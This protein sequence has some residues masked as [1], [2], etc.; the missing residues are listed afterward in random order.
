MSKKFDFKFM[1]KG[2][3]CTDYILIKILW[4]K[5]NWF[6]DCGCRFLNIFWET[7]KYIRGIRFSNEAGHMIINHKKLSE[8]TY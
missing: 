8:Y 1:S 3:Y 5:L 6:N 4:F 7:K 2:K